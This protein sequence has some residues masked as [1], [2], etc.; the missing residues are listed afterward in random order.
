MAQSSNYKLKLLYL[1][2]MF[3]E[4]TDEAHPLT[5]ARIQEYLSQYKIRADR[6]TLYADFQSLR[7]FGYD[8][9][10]VKSGNNFYYYLAILK[11]MI[12]SFSSQPC[13]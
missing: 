11:T 6:K 9:R 4:E 13:K 7:N 5:V 8:I 3:S 1:V 10:Q 12:H 2:K